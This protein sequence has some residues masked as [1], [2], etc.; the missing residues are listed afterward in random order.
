MTVSLV[1]GLAAVVILG[2]SAQWLAW[3]FRLPS[4]LLLMVFG[5]VAGPEVAGLVDPNRLFG[6][7]LLPVVSLSVALLLFEGGLTLQWAEIADYRRVV[8]R[9]VS[10]GALITWVLAALA[11]H[12]LAGLPWG[13]SVLLGAVLTVTGPTVVGPLLRQIRPTGAVGPILKWEGILIDPVGAVLAVLVLEGL[14]A[15]TA[16]GAVSA[17]FRSIF[18]TLIGGGGLGLAA[19]WLLT[20]LLHR[21]WIPD[22]L[23][24][25]VALALA[26]AVFVLGNLIH[27]EAGLLSVTLMGVYLGNQRRVDISHIVEFKETVQVLLI[28]ALFILM[29]ARIRIED[30]RMLGPGAFAFLAAMILI[31]RPISVLVCTAGSSLSKV[32]RIFLSCMAP[33]GIVAAAIASVFALRLEQMGFEGARMLVPLAFLIIVGTVALYGLGGAP[34]AYRLGLASP[35]PQGMLVMGAHAWGRAIATTLQG[36]GVRVLLVDTN[37]R[38]VRTA[39]LDGLNALHGNLLSE[40]TDERIDLQGMG[41]LLALTPNDEVN[42]LAAQHYTHLFGRAEV[43]RLVSGKKNGEG[44]GEPRSVRLLFASDADFATLGARFGDGAVCKATPLTE[45]FDFDAWRSEHGPDA[46]PLMT[47]S[48]SGTINVGTV[49]APLDPQPGETLVALVQEA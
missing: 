42:K 25:P 47:V 11:A 14:L 46:L 29:A 33:R 15:G 16:G 1:T 8:G 21:Y 41:R 23:D 39:R 2:V 17:A 48:G 36:L 38:N 37:A 9:L 49:T 45:Q 6:E 7:L 18:I 3:R 31:V 34:L 20:E 27:H 13:A 40:T 32:E 28:A 4:I 5:F 19:G 44:D 24:S 12:L 10:V 30:V 26:V 43:Y 35:N 22:H